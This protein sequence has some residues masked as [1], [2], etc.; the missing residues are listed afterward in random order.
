MNILVLDEVTEDYEK[1][2]DKRA[3]KHSAEDAISFE[4]VD[5]PF[6]KIRPQFKFEED[7]TFNESIEPKQEGKTDTIVGSEIDSFHIT[8]N[9]LQKWK[10]Y[11]EE[12]KESSFCAR[13]DDITNGGTDEFVEIDFKDISPRD[14]K[15]IKLGAVFYWNIGYEEKRGQ[16]SKKSIIR[17]QRVVK[18]DDKL[19]N[20]IGERTNYILNNLIIED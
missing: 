5:L 18:W 2:K 19:L 14:H 7:N 12:I 10:G 17:F 15:L 13:L 11:I 20:D 4:S 9:S 16:V 3:T 6:S 8:F 1:S